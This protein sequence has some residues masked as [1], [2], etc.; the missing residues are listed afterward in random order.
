[1][2]MFEVIILSAIGVMSLSSVAVYLYNQS[3]TEEYDDKI[4]N[5][6]DFGKLNMPVGIGKSIHLPQKPIV[7]ELNSETDTVNSDGYYDISREYNNISNRI[8]N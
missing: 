4:G 6:F 5:L 2:P 1:M 7:L 3:Y 8:S